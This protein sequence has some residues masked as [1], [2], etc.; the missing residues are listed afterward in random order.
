[1][2]VG[3]LVGRPMQSPGKRCIPRR[4]A[5]ST[6]G[7]CALA[8]WMPADP[9]SHVAWDPWPQGG[10][11]AGG[12]GPALTS[13]GCCQALREPPFLELVLDLGGVAGHAVGLRLQ[14]G[15]GCQGVGAQRQGCKAPGVA[16]SGLPA[17]Q[18]GIQ[19]EAAGVPV[20]THELQ[21]LL[22]QDTRS[23]LEG[24]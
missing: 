6:L 22:Q 1:M 23:W 10:C 5:H 13:G 21:R 8:S 12:Q 3:R 7:G 17:L 9:H 19:L 2:G 18:G 15:E 14:R 16:I 20:S 4:V 24:G 11:E